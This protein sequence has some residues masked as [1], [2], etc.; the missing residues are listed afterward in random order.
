M[1]IPLEKLSEHNRREIEWFKGILGS[2]SNASPTLRKLILLEADRE[3]K[4]HDEYFSQKE[5]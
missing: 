4:K 3:A 5:E 1:E 2:L